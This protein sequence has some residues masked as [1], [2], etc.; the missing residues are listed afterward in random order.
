MVSRFMSQDPGDCG[1]GD[2]GMPGQSA[3]QSDAPGV[4]PEKGLRVAGARR[5]QDI[6]GDVGKSVGKPLY[7]TFNAAPVTLIVDGA[8][9]ARG[10]RGAENQSGRSRL[11]RAS[12]PSSLDRRTPAGCIGPTADGN[13][14]GFT[15]QVAL[16]W[17]ARRIFPLPKG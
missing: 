9:I 5:P 10:R 3:I 4:V 7:D 12:L 2:S 15:G 6:V 16:Y 13:R 8:K 17:L 1:N 11:I 14:D